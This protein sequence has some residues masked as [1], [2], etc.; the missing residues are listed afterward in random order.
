MQT[1]KVMG[2]AVLISGLVLS[3]VTTRCAA[4]QSKKTSSG[5]GAGAAAPSG[6]RVADPRTVSAGTVQRV[7][8]CTAV[9]PPGWVMRSNQ[10]GSTADLDGPDGAHAGWGILGI[11][12]QM[13][14][15]YGPLHGPPEEAS[16][17]LAGAVAQGNAQ[18]LDA[19]AQFAGFFTKHQFT[20]GAQ[21]GTVLYKTWPGPMPSYYILSTFVATAPTGYTAR[22]REAEAVMVSISCRT[23]LRPVPATDPSDLP[24][25][26]RAW[27]GKPG[28]TATNE[29]DALQDYNAQ[30]GT[31]WAT[32]PSTGEKYLMDYS[33]QWNETGPDGP[34]Y[35]VKS[36]NSYEKL[37]TGWH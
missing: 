11:N 4:Q 19:P 23:Q 6:L 2:L 34:G 26:T 28:R 18:W 12:L 32:K 10:D 31:Q 13:R 14:A 16:L 27:R 1:K 30:L 24:D 29:G 9:L 7:G 35:Y 22:L 33:S 36:G 37:R 8:N 25:P 21:T 15:Y 3:T 5:S 17:V 20:T